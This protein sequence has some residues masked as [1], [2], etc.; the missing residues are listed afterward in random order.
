MACQSFW[1]VVSTTL[2]LTRCR[3]SG[4]CQQ[5]FPSGQYLPGCTLLRVAD[6]LRAAFHNMA[7]DLAIPKLPAERCDCPCCVTVRARSPGMQNVHVHQPGFPEC[8][9]SKTTSPSCQSVHL[10]DYVPGPQEFL[11]IAMHQLS[12]HTVN[13]AQLAFSQLHTLDS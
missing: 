8:I 2:L 6:S 3:D 1:H 11:K 10:K 5:Q 9:C 4:F 12:P 7:L 13:A